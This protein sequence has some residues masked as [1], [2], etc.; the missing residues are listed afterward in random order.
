MLINIS[1][2]KLVPRHE[3]LSKDEVKD[4]FDKY[5]INDVSNFPIILKTDPMAIYINAEIG[6]IVKIVRVSKDIG[7]TV[8]YRYC[9]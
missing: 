7:N 4:V 2:N 3:I 8:T 1:K 6:D 5:N 9:I